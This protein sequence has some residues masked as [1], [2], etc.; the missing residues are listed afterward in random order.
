MEAHL[1]SKNRNQMVLARRFR[2]E[3]SDEWGFRSKDFLG[4]LS[5]DKGDI[6]R[7]QDGFGHFCSQNRVAFEAIAEQSFS[8]HRG[9]GA[10]FEVQEELLVGLG[11]H[12]S[13]HKLEIV[14]MDFLH[15]G[16]C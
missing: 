3:V 5:H 4:F 11:F 10:G 13:V 8:R 2:V 16:K 9:D 1:P 15:G 12:P 6:V 14:F 7:G